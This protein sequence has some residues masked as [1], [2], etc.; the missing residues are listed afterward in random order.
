MGDEQ[1]PS[2]WDNYETTFRSYQAYLE[3]KDKAGR[4]RYDLDFTDLLYASNYKA[5][6]G[7][8]Q[9]DL[10]KLESK[11]KLERYSH[12]LEEIHQSFGQRGLADLKEEDFQTLVSYAERMIELC[13]EHHL[14]GLG[15]PYCSAL[16]HMHF[17]NLFPVI[18]RN[19][20]LG[21]G[22][23]NLLETGAIQ[24]SGQ[25]WK[26]EK[27]YVDLMR[28]LHTHIKNSG[29]FLR[30]TDRAFFNK[31]KAMYEAHKQQAKP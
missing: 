9:E 5:G 14:K 4:S 24:K 21:I 1:E 28:E 18:D 29:K 16:F 31:G 10:S 12:L 20:L 6:S 7:S 3:Q 23:G 8:I 17:P 15:V 26:P 22:V 19:V 11:A 30:E 25:I 27:Y 2:T 13:S